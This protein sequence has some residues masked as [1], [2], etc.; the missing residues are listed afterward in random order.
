[1]LEPDI[2]VLKELLFSKDEDNRNLGY[3]MINSIFLN[4]L[5]KHVDKNSSI[6]DKKV[7]VTINN[8]KL[9]LLS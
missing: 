3:A 6:E 2:N 5:S 1:M 4:V 7:R 8:H 9:I